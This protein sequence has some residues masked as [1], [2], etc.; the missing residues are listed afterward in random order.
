MYPLPSPNGSTI[1]V[2]G[3]GQGLLILWQGSLP[4]KPPS[5]EAALK[6]VNG[7]SKDAVTIIDSD[8]EEPAKLFKD[9]QDFEKTEDEHDVMEP[10]LP[11]TQTLDLSLGVSVLHLSFPCLPSKHFDSTLK[12]LPRL[13][14]DRIVVALACSDFS[15]R[16]LT[17]PLLPPSA[18]T[19]MKTDLRGTLPSRTTASGYFGEQM[20]VFS[21][22]HGHRSVPRGVSMT[23]TMHPRSSAFTSDTII[24]RHVGGTANHSP[25]PSGSGSYVHGQ[26][27]SIPASQK[28]DLIVASHSSDF[29]GLLLIHRVAIIEDS[30]TLDAS[31]LDSMV[32]WQV[33]HL[34]SPA[35]SIQFN[36]SLYPAPRHSEVLITD[37][38]GV[39]RIFD[40]LSHRESHIKGSWL[41]S[42][43]P[44]LQTPIGSVK[45]LEPILGAQ[46][47][48][49][50]KAVVV[51]LADGGWGVWD[52]DNRGP[53]AKKGL[54]LSADIT[55]GVPSEF[56]I[57]GS[58]SISKASENAVNNSDRIRGLAPMTPGT[59]K[60]RQEDLFAGSTFRT[61]GLARGGISVSP[62]S[63]SSIYK[64][65]DE[66][67]LLWHGDNIAI[68]PSL[69]TYWQT[70][71]RGAGNFFGQE[72]RGQFKHVDN[73]SL[74]HE[75]KN[76]AS[77]FPD[78]CMCGTKSGIPDQNNVLI[79]GER[80]I[81]I[82]TSQIANPSAQGSLYQEE[83]TVPKNCCLLAIG[84]LDINGV[85]RILAN[86]S[87]NL[88]NNDDCLDRSKSVDKVDFLN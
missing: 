70:K 37:A 40:C 75:T 87:N 4:C 18:Q 26:D 31:F 63:S 36:S 76:K 15:I 19:K 45:S 30:S 13:L 80:S 81:S 66:S 58:L 49:G 21:S 68:L 2:C 35:L 34:V 38:R 3:H 88:Q 17:I 83:T 27:S 64:T 10:Y 71:M 6:P 14:S 82:L 43:Y 32:P 55:G 67:I 1:I 78:F 25:R 12:P 79:S 56:A 7:A 9:V 44:A 50:G 47:C 72:N 39:I 84:E 41:I 51:L 57:S 86:M 28:W 46:W 11:I 53:K 33:Q 22:G 77:L 59:R 24:N 5:K 60:T 85:D 62:A 54:K 20:I 69:L 42:L 74:G 65:D 29:S 8:Q 52:L 73:A 23:T 48:L 61:Y 16:V